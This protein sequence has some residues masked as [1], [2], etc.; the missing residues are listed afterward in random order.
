VGP[1]PQDK[2]TFEESFEQANI[3]PAYALQNDHPNRTQLHVIAKF[4]IKR[5]LKKDLLIKQ[6]KN[7]FKLLIT[8]IFFMQQWNYSNNTNGI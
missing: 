2:T 7:F 6:F 5:K 1:L 4:I 3:L 8:K